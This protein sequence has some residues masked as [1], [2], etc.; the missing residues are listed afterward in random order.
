MIFHSY[1]SLPE[2]NR[3]KYGW[4]WRKNK[5]AIPARVWALPLTGKACRRWLA[6]H[7]PEERKQV[8]RN[9]IDWW[10]GGYTFKPPAVFTSHLR[11]A[12]TNFAMLV[13]KQKQ[14][15][16]KGFHKSPRRT[17][18]SNTL[19]RSLWVM[20]ETGHRSMMNYAVMP[21]AHFE[22]MI[23]KVYQGM[24]RDMIFDMNPRRFPDFAPQSDQGPRMR[25]SFAKTKHC[26]RFRRHAGDSRSVDLGRVMLHGNDDGLKTTSFW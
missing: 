9:R 16:G 7:H 13:E 20:I 4:L 26:K 2:G 10:F 1:V 21:I 5:M 3:Q 18:T 12:H 19:N 25:R 11:M 23:H 22:A 8:P 24:S 15:N 14:L 6:D 17:K